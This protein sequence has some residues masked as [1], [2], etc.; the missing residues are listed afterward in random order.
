MNP[1]PYNRTVVQSDGPCQPCPKIQ[2][3]FLIDMVIIVLFIWV[4]A[5]LGWDWWKNRDL[6]KHLD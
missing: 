5:V 1:E 6:Y 2:T 4:V 3:G